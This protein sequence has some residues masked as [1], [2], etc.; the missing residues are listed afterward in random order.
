MRPFARDSAVEV[1]E[2]TIA[3]DHTGL[4]SE[5]LVDGTRFAPVEDDFVDLYEVVRFAAQGEKFAGHSTA[6]EAEIV[7]AP[8]AI[9]ARDEGIT[10]EA[11]IP[12]V[13]STIWQYRV[14]L[15]ARP[16]FAAVRCGDA[17]LFVPAPLRFWA[18]DPSWRCSRG[19][20]RRRAR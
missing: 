11:A 20:T 8:E 1:V 10:G 14:S 7:H 15:V 19:N 12:G 9:V 13:R 6:V 3:E 4:V 16:V 18:E 2:R 17:S 5:S